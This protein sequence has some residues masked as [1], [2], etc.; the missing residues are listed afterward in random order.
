MLRQI[1][2][3]LGA[4]GLVAASMPAAPSAAAAPEAKGRIRALVIGVVNYKDGIASPM[5]GA[6]NDSVLIAET[7]IREGAKA[8]DVT[9]LL[10]PPTPELL[11]ACG[12]P[13]MR[14][15]KVKP[16]AVGTRANILA[17]MKRI[18][19]PRRAMEGINAMPVASGA[20]MSRAYM[21]HRS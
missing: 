6:F 11:A 21:S 20:L 12:N 5:I 4:L 7:L 19:G 15:T 2:L 14:Q 18:V 8:E 13:R 10:D 1:M 17:A 16:D 3:A 9:L